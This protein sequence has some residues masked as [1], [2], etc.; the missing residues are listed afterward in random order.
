MAIKFERVSYQ[1]QGHDEKAY[2]A[3]SDI[4]V[5]IEKQASLLHS[6]AKLAVVKRPW[7]NI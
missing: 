5:N 1:Y 2:L 4:N 6:S 7:F 3:L